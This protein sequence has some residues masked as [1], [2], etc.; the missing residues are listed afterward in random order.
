MTEEGLTK[1]IEKFGEEDLRHMKLTIGDHYL[2]LIYLGKDGTFKVFQDIDD[3][4]K[5]LSKDDVRPITFAEL[6]YTS[7]FADASTMPCFVTRYPV[8][9]YGG[10]YPS[11]VYLKSTIKGEVREELDDQ[12]QKSGIVATEF[13]IYQTQ[14]M[15]SLSPNR[16]HLGRLGADGI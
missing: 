12:W 10:I 2:G 4:P 16:K 7:V 11:Y 5:D 15:N 6:L 13:P 8:I 9:N 1:V 14:F 3:L